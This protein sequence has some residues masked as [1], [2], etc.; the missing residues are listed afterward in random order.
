MQRT[1][2]LTGASRGIGRSIP[3]RLLKD[4]H[5][6]SLGLRDP[7]A[8]RGTDLDVATVLHHAYDANDPASVEAW[9]DSTVR[10]WGAI[11]T[12]IHSAG[13]L[14]R[15]PLLF[16]DGEE[17]QLDELWAINVKGPW[18]LTRAAWPYLVTRYGQAARVSH[19]GP[20]TL[21]AHSSSSCCS[22][23]SANNNGVR[24][25]IPAQW[26]TVSMAPQ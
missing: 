2:L 12:V 19:P 26:I 17:Q 8:L 14:H 21:I 4:G 25:K 23:P 1:V 5:R 9:V 10:N 22:S 15:T 20:V 18:W 3:R 13:I 6:L 16:A 11:D 24:C 7:Q